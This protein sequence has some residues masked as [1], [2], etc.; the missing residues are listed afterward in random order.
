M[1]FKREKRKYD[2]NKFFFVE[3]V[4]D[5]FKVSS[6]EQLHIERPDLLPSEKV[7]H[8]NDTETPIHKHFYSRLNKDGYLSWKQMTDTYDS[9]VREV[10]GPVIGEEFIYQKF[11]SFRVQL[12]NIIPHGNMAVYEF[13]SDSDSGYNH[14]IGE[15]NF[16]IALTTMNNNSA[17]WIESE[18]G[19][20]DYSPMNMVPGEYYKF[21]GNQLVHGNREND[22]GLT[23]VSFDFRVLP[24][25][26][27]NENLG[28]SSKSSNRK[29]VV[30]DYYK[31]L[32]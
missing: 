15:V 2:L 28:L 9:F 6:L 32:Q 5:C 1:T 4:R 17:T 11:P 21:C 20:G 22:T 3:L 19:K 8:K 16:Q 12:P 18:V 14:P 30:G 26:A 31:K 23:R 25:N 27:Y 10:V 13:H 7:E 24:L 29:F